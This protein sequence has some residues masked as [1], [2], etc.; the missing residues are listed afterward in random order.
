ME[1]LIAQR[2]FE[3]YG[4]AND[5]RSDVPLDFSWRPD[6]IRRYMDQGRW[7]LVFNALCYL[8]GATEEGSA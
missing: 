7:D 1:H 4:D 5:A 3:V 2:M 6:D 8:T